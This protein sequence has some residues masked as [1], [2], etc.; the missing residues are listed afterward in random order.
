MVYSALHYP[1]IIL[2]LDPVEMQPVVGDSSTNIG[3]LQQGIF[4][5]GKFFYLHNYVGYYVTV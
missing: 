2:V 1:C 3:R 4:L 5:L